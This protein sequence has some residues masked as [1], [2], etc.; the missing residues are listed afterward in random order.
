MSLAVGIFLDFNKEPWFISTMVVELNFN[1][2]QQLYINIGF[3]NELA[4]MG[5]SMPRFTERAFGNVKALLDD[6]I[7]DA[8]GNG[9]RIPYSEFR[10][11]RS[12]FG[13]KMADMGEGANRSMYKRMYAHMTDDLK[14]G[15]DSLGFGKM[16]ADCSFVAEFCGY[17][18]D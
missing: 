17:A 13:E 18:S 7:F 1:S 11:V 9:G 10:K 15:A 16:F 6:L 4:A 12:F 2:V 8:S 3:Y 5:K 14:F